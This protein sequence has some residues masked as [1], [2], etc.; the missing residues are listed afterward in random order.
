MLDYET[1]YYLTPPSVVLHSYHIY[2]HCRYH[3]KLFL[4]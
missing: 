2:L 4:L 1:V 3:R